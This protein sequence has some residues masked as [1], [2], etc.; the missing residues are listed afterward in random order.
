[1]SALHAPQQKARILVVEDEAIVARDIQM[2]LR[3]LGY[4]VAGHTTRGEDAVA[5]VAQSPPDLVV[6]D[7][8]LAGAMDGIAAAHS[9]RT[10][11]QHTVPVVFLTAFDADET[12]ARAK[13][14]EPFGYILKPFTERD[15]RTVIE[16]ALYKCQAESRLRD[17]GLYSQAILDNMLDGV[18][19]IGEGGLIESCNLSARRIFGFA[20]A[21]EVLGTP[22]TRLT[23]QHQSQHLLDFI[24]FVRDGDE[25][26]ADGQT[27]ELTGQRQDGSVF[28]LSLTLSE[29]THAG[30]AECIA[31]ARDLSQQRQAA[32]EIYNLAF[33]DRLTHLPNRRLLLDNLKH[34]LMSSARSG[35]HG[36]LILLDLDHFKRLNDTLGH[37]MG[38]ELLKQVAGRLKACV[39]ESD[40]IARLGGDEFV[41]LL[42]ALSRDA[43]EAAQQA[44]VMV[45]KLLHEMGKPYSLAGHAH[46]NTPSLGIVVFLAHEYSLEALLQNAEIAMYRAKEAG[47]TTFR[48]FDAA[49]QA[50]VMAHAARATD[51]Q[52]ALDEQE[53]VLY[54]QVQ[55]NRN[56]EP[57]GAEALVRWQHAVRGMVSPAD[58]IALAEETRMILPLGQWV[59]EQACA[60]LARWAH[61]PEKSH[62]TMS[63]NVSALQF[64]QPDFVA[65]VLGALQKTGAN[66]VHLKLELTESML[67]HDVLGVINKMNALKDH[68]VKFSLDD[69]GTGYSSLS[70]LK[71]LPLDQLKIDQSF[72]RDLLSD[73]NDAVIAQAIIALGHSLGLQVIAEGVETVEQRYVLAGIHCDA[74]QGY[75]FARP[76]SAADLANATEE[77]G[78]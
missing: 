19:T 34:V 45:T 44:E 48:F 74:F 13:L 52:R 9:I 69:F 49:M 42:S 47:R 63:I 10:N 46:C 57:I 66:P 68:A 41:V 58:F 6:M 64:A 53:F 71:R 59:L 72:V 12:L 60:E 51:L 73:P 35:E 62:W 18:I 77:I 15:L 28:P 1:M 26:T 65:S 55:V 67:V 2:Q 17:E 3:E 50:A 22:V 40:Q 5:M 78:L 56:G 27:R 31:L 11:S 4:A 75:Y 21:H 14:T 70:Y 61:D 54:Y 32:E 24:R 36:A 37:K 25:R 30:R 76:V 16:M 43:K 23:P 7:I 20:A 29:I 38:D 33:Y 8:Q 39:R